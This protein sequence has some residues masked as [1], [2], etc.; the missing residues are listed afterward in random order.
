MGMI[1]HFHLSAS[2]LAT[3][4]SVYNVLEKLYCYVDSSI[5]TVP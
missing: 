1:L 4:A 5:K 2:V 3:S